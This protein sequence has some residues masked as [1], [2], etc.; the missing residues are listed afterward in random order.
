MRDGAGFLQ[1]V[2]RGIGGLAFIAIV[3]VGGV[4]NVIDNLKSQ[5]DPRAILLNAG[6]VRFRS[7]A[8]ISANPD[9]RAKQSGCFCAMDNFELFA[10]H[11]PPFAFQIE[12]L[13]CNHSA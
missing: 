13:A 7:I 8:E 2:E 3:A 11:R 6:K 10:S 9:G 5:T 1:A 12:Y 4:E